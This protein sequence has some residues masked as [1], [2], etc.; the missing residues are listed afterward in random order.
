MRVV[1]TVVSKYTRKNLNCTPKAVI[2]PIKVG[3][4]HYSFIGCCFFHPFGGCYLGM[5]L[6]FSLAIWD[7]NPKL[8]HNP[9]NC[10]E[11]HLLMTYN[12][13]QKRSKTTSIQPHFI[14]RR[15]TKI[16]A[17]LQSVPGINT[18]WPCWTPEICFFCMWTASVLPIDSPFKNGG[19]YRTTSK[20]SC[21]LFK[22]SKS[23]S[24]LIFHYWT[25]Q[26]PMVLWIST[27]L[28]R[29]REALRDG[30]VANIA[31]T[32]RWIPWFQSV[33]QNFSIHSMD[34]MYIWMIIQYLWIWYIYV[35]YYTVFMD[36]IYI[37]VIWIDMAGFAVI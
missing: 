2:P 7:F 5:Q 36:M 3:I 27:G 28:A 4:E 18:S 32:D 26:K 16:Y 11:I 34:I 37:Y 20:T 35:D 22:K 10:G 31:C 6:G 12:W 25:P 14:H 33:L 8:G 24:P 19:F 9:C 23:L 17:S 15:A 29:L 21:F 1:T 13:Y 30:Q